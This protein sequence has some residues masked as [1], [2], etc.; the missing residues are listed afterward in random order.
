[1]F[2]FSV[3]GLPPQQGQLKV[4]LPHDDEVA[5]VTLVDH[6]GQELAI[7]INLD[8][9]SPLMGGLEVVARRMKELK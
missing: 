2:S 5:T 1:M 9:L 4:E 8:R 7:R 3:N 6:D